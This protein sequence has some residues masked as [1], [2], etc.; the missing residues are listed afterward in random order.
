MT[1]EEELK[2]KI[3]Y[4]ELENENLKL[5]IQ[6]MTWWQDYKDTLKEGKKDDLNINR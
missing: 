3:E 1:E 5:R 4:L 2:L 6:N